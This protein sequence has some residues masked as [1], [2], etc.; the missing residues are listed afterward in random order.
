[1][2]VFLNIRCCGSVRFTCKYYGF[3]QSIFVVFNILPI[4]IYRVFCV[5]IYY[6]AC[7]NARVLRNWLSKI[8]IPTHKSIANSRC[9]RFSCKMIF[10]NNLFLNCYTAV[11]VKGYVVHHATANSYCK[12]FHVVANTFQNIERIVTDFQV[13][14]LT[15]N[16][17]TTIL[18]I[19]HNIGCVAFYRHFVYERKLRHGIAHLTIDF[20]TI[21]SKGIK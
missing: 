1:M 7:R 12:Q 17:R 2:C 4:V 3:V 21:F 16:G 9:F 10:F 11:Y 8:I 18:V 14:S 5:F 6:P 19:I 15:F 20:R 13:N